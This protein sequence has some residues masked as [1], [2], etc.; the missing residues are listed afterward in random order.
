MNY[1]GAQPTGVLAALPMG[2]QA[3]VGQFAVTDPD[4]PMGIQSLV[5][6]QEELAERLR[7][8]GVPKYGL[9]SLFRKI[10]PKELRKVANVVVPTVLIASG[11]P[12]LAAAYSAASTKLEGGST[13]DALFSAG[14]TYVGGKIGGMDGL[15]GI[16]QIAAQAATNVAFDKARGVDTQTALRGAIQQAAT[17]AI[18]QTDTGQSITDF[19]GDKVS[20]ISEGAQNLLSLGNTDTQ[21][22]NNAVETAVE[23]SVGDPIIPVSGPEPVEI[24]QLPDLTDLTVDDFIDDEDLLAGGIRP[25]MTASLAMANDAV[26]TTQ[27]DA[28]A[29]TSTGTSTGTTEPKPNF[30]QRAKTAVGEGLEDIYK[31]L[32]FQGDDPSKRLPDFLGSGAIVGGGIATLAG[33]NMQD[34]EEDPTLTDE[35]KAIIVNYLEGTSGSPV[36]KERVAPVIDF[37]KQRRAQYLNTGGEIVG[38]GTGTSD[39]VPALLSDGEFVMTAKAVR[40][41]GGG[42]REKGAAKMYA[43]MNKLEKGAA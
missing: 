27:I 7:A 19:V 29:G 22:V 42:D 12:G 39:S 15:S 1:Y 30:F 25:D 24:K 4:S 40:N 32:T 18:L 21:A 43:L 9:G 5:G 2:A 6:G 31:N 17:Q 10:V 36:Y 3:S 16:E 20:G 37:Y 38:P 23:D 28:G 35:Q 14:K 26:D 33:L 8:M 11:N 41:A 13:E 34:I